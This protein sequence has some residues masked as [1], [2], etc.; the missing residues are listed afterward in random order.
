MSKMFVHYSGT[1]DAFSKLSNIA[2][3]NNKIVFIKGGT[4]G[5][6][7]AI[8]THG[9]YYANLNDALAGLKYISS[10]KAGGVT[11]TAQGPN[12]VIEFSAADP[13]T[14]SVSA[15]STGV[16]IGL[17][18]D[19]KKSVSD[20]TA[21][22]AANAIA[23]T[24]EASARG[25]AI[26]TAKNE[27]TAEINKKADSSVVTDIDGRVQTIEADY[28]KAADIAGKLDS[29]VYEAKIAELAKADTDNLQAAKNYADAEI[30]K[31]DSATVSAQVEANKTAIAT[32]NGSDTG[33]S[34]REVVQDEVAAQLTSENITESFDTLKE[35]AEYLSSH[36]EDVTEINRRLT[37]L[38]GLVSETAVATQ[39]TNAINA[40]NVTDSAVAGQYVSAV[41]ES[42]GKITVTRADLPTYTLATGSANGTVAFNGSDVAVKGLA[43]AAYT[44]ASAYATA[45]QG[46]K[47]DAAAPANTVYT[48]T[49]VD[50]F[51]AWE[52]L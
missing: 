24:D 30:A 1:V 32:L 19:F 36:P 41:S 47:A 52:E 28:L 6:G 27:L 13:T 42:A 11:A 20:N 18:E 15:G 25:T 39:I 2:D 51:W 35:M 49:E 38:E 44:E 33:K 40:L 21:G 23:I 43:S 46:T 16:T 22:V 4:D 31:L 17:T 14:V 10:V 37:S 34:V 9:N 50:A 45:A 8:Y 48:K 7:A 12:G 29:S 26:T 3:Y 5:T